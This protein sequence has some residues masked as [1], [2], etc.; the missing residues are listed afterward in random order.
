MLG[1]CT[2]LSHHDHIAQVESVTGRRAHGGARI[3]SA[4]SSA[5]QLGD[6]L[7]PD[8]RAALSVARSDVSGSRNEMAV[9]WSAQE[10]ERC[11][12]LLSKRINH[13]VHRQTQPDE[14]LACNVRVAA[15]AELLVWE[16]L[17]EPVA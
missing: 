9:S 14:R 7:L 4:H 13:D 1:A 17:N 5:T 3:R 6:Q 16:E 2:H 15:D 10:G 11:M 12:T 8:G